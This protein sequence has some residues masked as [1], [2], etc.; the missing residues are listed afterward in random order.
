MKKALILGLFAIALVSCSSSSEDEEEKA[1]VYSS[2]DNLSAEPANGGTDG[3]Y[4]KESIPNEVL[5]IFKPVLMEE[6]GEQVR[7]TIDLKTTK[8]D[9][10]LVLRHSVAELEVKT[11]AKMK[12]RAL[13][14][15]KRWYVFTAGVYQVNGI[16][17]Y[18]VR[19]D[20]I[21]LIANG[22]K[23]AS[24]SNYRYL[25]YSSNV[26]VSSEDFTKRYITIAKGSVT[27]DVFS[28]SKADTTYK[29]S[30]ISDKE[31]QLDMVSP[32][33]YDCTILEKE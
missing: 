1:E 17:K 9:Y 19:K 22:E 26:V 11:D 21:Y 27:S 6:D 32:K 29:C 5:E 18:E 3:E 15:K 2:Y 20:G 13:R 25:D 7:D 16:D 28:V 10:R 12:A 24:L 30:R 31:I 8:T 33:E 23:W 14:G 4:W